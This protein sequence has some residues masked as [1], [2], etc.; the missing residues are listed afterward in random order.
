MPKYIKQ[1]VKIIIEFDS[2]GDLWVNTLDETGRILEQVT[3]DNDEESI[4]SHIRAVLTD[5]SNGEYNDA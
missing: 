5:I 3:L 1:F 4:N 2:D